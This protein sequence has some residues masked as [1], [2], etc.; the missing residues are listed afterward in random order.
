M[1]K[2]N[3]IFSKKIGFL[4]II[5]LVIIIFFLVTILIIKKVPFK[6]NNESNTQINL[7]KNNIEDEKLSF[8]YTEYENK[9]KQIYFKYP[10][11]YTQ[12]EEYENNGNFVF[13]A[14]NPS[15]QNY[16][17]LVINDV[18]D[19]KSIDEYIETFINDLMKF[20]HISNDDIK[21]VATKLGMVDAYYIQHVTKYRDKTK[22]IY[23]RIAIKNK[24]VYSI[25]YM[26]EDTNF[27][28]SKANEIFDTFRFTNNNAETD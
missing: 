10:K 23:Q 13:M 7:E 28:D 9:D 20:G 15:T 5:T 11:E 14:T 25:S 21:K 27:K 22:N 12:I 18:Q 6:V 8:D 16:I 4:S 1:K 26:G 24:K 3:K 17:S 2:E 19:D